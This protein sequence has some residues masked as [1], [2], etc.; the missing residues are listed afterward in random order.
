MDGA[1]GRTGALQAGLAGPRGNAGLGDVS[2]DVPDLPQ[3]PDTLLTGWFNCELEENG[4]PDTCGLDSSSFGFWDLSR[5]IN[6]AFRCRGFSE[7]STS[8]EARG[9]VAACT[10]VLQRARQSCITF[11]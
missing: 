1:G 2:A 9:S 5:R 11:L 4:A 7:G 3:L 10:V 8:A 6:V